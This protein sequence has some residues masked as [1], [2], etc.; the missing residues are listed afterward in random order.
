[1]CF[2]AVPSYEERLRELGLFSLEEKGLRGQLIVAFQYLEE[3][4]E[5]DGNRLFSR[6]CGNRTRGK[7]FKLKKGRFRLDIR[8][9]SVYNESGE[10]LERV[11]QRG[12]RCPN[13]GHIEGHVGR[14]SKQPGL[15]EDVPAYYRGVGLDDL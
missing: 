3:A 13:P 5:K 8:K 2:A 9:K 7:G 6:A 11:A 1:L 14:G 4:Y 10:T 15:V 12:G